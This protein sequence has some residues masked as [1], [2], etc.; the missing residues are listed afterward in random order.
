MEYYSIFAHG[1]IVDN[2]KLQPVVRRLNKHFVPYIHFG[3]QEYMTLVS[4]T[5]TT[6]ILLT[7]V[8][9]KPF[10]EEVVQALL[11]HPVRYA[12]L[13]SISDDKN[14]YQHA[15]KKL[16]DINLIEKTFFPQNRFKV[17]TSKDIISQP[18]DICLDSHNEMVLAKY[19]NANYYEN[20]V[21]NKVSELYPMFQNVLNANPFSC[22]M[23]TPLK[24]IL[25]QYATK[26]NTVGLIFP[27]GLYTTNK[28]H[29]LQFKKYVNHRLSHIVKIETDKI[30]TKNENKKNFKN[31][32]FVDIGAF[33]VFSCKNVIPHSTRLKNFQFSDPERVVILSLPNKNKEQ[34]ETQYKDQKQKQVFERLKEN[35]KKYLQ[36]QKLY[37]QKQKEIYDKR[38]NR[39]EKKNQQEHLQNLQE[40]FNN[41]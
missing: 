24:E 34:T 22:N 23:T 1:H 4:D 35:K 6:F 30:K 32:T 31:P 9:G 40:L 11:K 26:S 27:L 21:D 29:H 25:I 19:K 39:R 5:V 14:V 28:N 10:L 8:F 20:F 38:R 17:F 3:T 13:Y 18:L 16:F 7:K 15:V 12:D 41:L 33:F 37:R 2:K 36:Q